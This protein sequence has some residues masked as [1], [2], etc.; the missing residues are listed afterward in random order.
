M[1]TELPVSELVETI[2]T[3]RELRFDRE[4]PRLR[5]PHGSAEVF[6]DIDDLGG[7]SIISVNAIV[8]D[9]VDLDGE[10][11]ILALRAVNDR[12]KSIRFGKLLL[13]VTDRRIR[14]EYNLLGDFLQPAE[15]MNALTSVAQM[16]DDH[17]DLLQGEL[18]SGRR[19]ADRQ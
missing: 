14:L 9:E 13:D 17:D 16:A 19:A 15:I 4:G 7:A 1:H 6:I 18:G 5:V 8:L 2:L 12:N 3:D 10:R 11:E